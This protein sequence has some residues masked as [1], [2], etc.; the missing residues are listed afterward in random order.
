MQTLGG[1]N[2][3]SK[4]FTSTSIRIS[5]S[6]PEI[7]KDPYPD[8]YCIVYSSKKGEFEEVTDIS[9]VVKTINHREVSI[10]LT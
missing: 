7:V 1:F 8:Y 2:I 6:L 10:L 9:K 3:R 4:H 5:W